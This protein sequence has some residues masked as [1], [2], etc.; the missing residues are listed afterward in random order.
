MGTLKWEGPPRL[1]DFPLC[2]FS[3]FE[4]KRLF[5][6]LHPLFS[7]FLPS[8]SKFES[9]HQSTQSPPRTRPS[10]INRHP[11]LFTW[12]FSKLASKAG[13][14]YSLATRPPRSRSESCLAVSLSAPYRSSR[15]SP[16]MKE[17]WSIAIFLPSIQSSHDTHRRESFYAPPS[18]LQSLS[19]CSALEGVTFE[20]LEDPPASSG[21]ELSPQYIS[22]LTY[23]SHAIQATSTYYDSIPILMN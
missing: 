6:V 4:T 10:S 9:L 13:I 7:L 18:D 5:P 12:S 16:C 8:L 14:D 17:H 2:C 22:S 3:R 21:G 23:L 11:Y 1:F 19:L 15:S 20:P